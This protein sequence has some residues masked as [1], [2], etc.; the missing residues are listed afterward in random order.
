[1]TT[2]SAVLV[3]CLTDDP[4]LPPASG[5]FGGSVNVMFNLGTYL[6]RR[7]KSVIYV[8]SSA[9]NNDISMETI[10][11]RCSIFRIPVQHDDGTEVKY[12]QYAPYIGK[13][14]STCL[15]NLFGAAGRLTIDTIVSYNWNSGLVAC[16]LAK[17]TS[18]PH[19]HFVLAL[20]NSRL[21]AGESDKKV[22]QDWISAEEKIFSEAD[23]IVAASTSEVGE[24]LSMY[25]TCPATK[26]TCIHLGV[27]TDV[28]SPRPRSVSDYVC[29]SS[30]RFA[31]GAEEIS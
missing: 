2:S 8:V 26:V 25:P 5:A 13:I 3:L 9:D 11:T 21:L 31:Q 28:F 23:C 6:V 12:F 16:E 10:G 20:G 7:N 22:N 17:R 18:I 27:D 30:S 15:A 29:W 19:V 14:S 1:M 4:F 24:I